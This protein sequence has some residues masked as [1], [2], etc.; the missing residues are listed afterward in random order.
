M[1]E[2]HL[3][4]RLATLINADL[5]P[6][7][8]EVHTPAEALRALMALI[9]GFARALSHGHFR[10]TA[11]DAPVT[12]PTLGLRFGR[13]RAFHIHPAAQGAGADP[14]TII[15]AGLA[16][17]GAAYALTAI[18]AVGDYAER[19]APDDKPSYLFNGALN[20]H[21]QGGV[22]P[23]IFGGPIRVGSTVVSAGISTERVALYGDS[24]VDWH[25]G[26]DWAEGFTAGFG[27]GGGGARTPVEGDNTLQTRAT[28]RVVDLI[29]EGEMN[30]LVDG[31]KSV[32]IDGVAVEN[33]DGSKNVQGI[34]F[35]W[36]SGLP[37]QAA[38]AG[39]PN[40]ESERSINQAV[41][42]ATPLVHS[43][44]NT[45]VDTARVTLGFPRLVS[46]NAQGDTGAATV[47]FAIA[48]QAAGGSYAT[49]IDQ[50]IRDKNTS[51]AELSW[52]VPL[53]GDAPFNIKVTR[54]TADSDSDRLHNKLEWARL[55]EITEVKQSYPYS[56]VMGLTAE[57]DKFEGQINK[58][59]YEVY[60]LIVD[61]PANYDP[62]TRSYTGLWD[63]TFKG[64]WTDNP[65]WCVYKLLTER[66]F[67]LG[68]EIA[69]EFLSATK[70]ELYTLAQFCDE[71]VPDGEGGTEPRFRFTGIVNKATE[72]K[73]LLDHML[74]ACKA[75][76]YY[77]AGSLV[78]VADAP[79]DPSALLANANVIDGAFSYSDLAVSE[80]VSAIAM[81]FNDPE[82][83]YRLGIELVVDD[84]LV[85]KY[86]YR[87]DDRAAM[88]CTSRSQAQRLARHLLFEQ[89]YESDTLHYA[90]SL[91]HASIRPGAVIR[92][93]DASATG[94]RAYG[95][96]KA[97]DAASL[98][99]TL[100]AL[101]ASLDTSLDW[102]A[103]VVLA[104]GSVGEA[105]VASLRTADHALVLEEALSSAPLSHALCVLEAPELEPKLWR[106]VS[107]AERD[108]LEFAFSARAYH[109]DKYTAVEDGVTVS[110]PA[111]SLLP[112]G[113][114]AA[115]DAIVL[116]EYLYQDGVVVKTALSLSVEGGEDARIGFID[117][118][119]K[120]P[121]DDA[122]RPAALTRARSAEIK[123]VRVG[124]YQAR[125]RFVDGSGTIKSPW[126]PSVAFTALGKTAPPSAPSNL[127]IVIRPDTGLAISID[128]IPDLDRDEYSFWVGATFETAT[129]LARIKSTEYLWTTAQAGT[130]TFWVKAHDTSDH[131]NGG[132]AVVSASHIVTAPATPEVTLSYEGAHLVLAWA[133]TAS[134]FRI[135]AYE[136]HHGSTLIAEVTATAYRQR[137]EWTGARTVTVTARDIAVNRSSAA[138]V[139]VNPSPPG[140]PQVRVRTIDNTALF[141]A[142]SESLTC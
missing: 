132:S 82:N 64:A 104:D 94:A 65:A 38:L 97:Y 55:T 80:R 134:A 76:L 107:V 2:I 51:A 11:D 117:V 46:V 58:R 16:L 33:A 92:Q 77:G 23:L 47:R 50:T 84:A 125:A 27:G 96:I 1:I 67:G 91:E 121:G 66:R 136:I 7:K 120:S 10:L 101:D 42:Q 90:T 141:R 45:G 111:Y 15:L 110:V 59:E 75:T 49:V 128:A 8:L 112:T 53:E 13:A 4:G 40:V 62:E 122:Y 32:Y 17:A 48:V 126:T 68:G 135:A 63:G 115:P 85:A 14:V 116:E 86:G 25:D 74:G 21:Q 35:E 79:A 133:E 56:A 139:E 19:E 89:E 26:T 57:A 108:V 109:A 100:D 106:V 103:H 71:Q 6:L 123:D 29:G 5:L 9:P 95:R 129:R 88:F 81:S 99:L 70:W 73:K 131:I 24:R 61:V 98:T 41:T 28:I 12:E 83:D 93:S 44:T 39:I 87:Q 114:L 119:M 52:R 124:A 102:T 127:Q 137:I 54:H 130:H 22:V 69:D 43:I 37:D 118:H 18:P 3:H 142:C 138:S 113:P 31:L 140:A 30:G 36:R 34:N 105:G 20:T 72:A 78:P 60:G